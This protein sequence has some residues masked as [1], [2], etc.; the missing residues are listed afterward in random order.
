MAVV[1]A[2]LGVLRSD[3]GT[4]PRALAYAGVDRAALITRLEEL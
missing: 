3:L 1:G 4:V 2:L